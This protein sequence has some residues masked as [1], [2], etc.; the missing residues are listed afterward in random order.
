MTPPPPPPRVVCTSGAGV[1]RLTLDHPPL[2]I[3]TREVLAHIR[4]EL[5]ALAPEPGLRVLLV[6]ATGAHFSGGADVRE[7]LPPSTPG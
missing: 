3:L 1:G 2:N 7:H 5:A 4:T 6:T